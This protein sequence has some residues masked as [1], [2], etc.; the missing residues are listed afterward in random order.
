MQ[1][2]HL[3][4]SIALKADAPTSVEDASPHQ[5]KRLLQTQS[6]FA[7]YHIAINL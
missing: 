4:T 7:F 3:G 2:L 1:F 6:V 5:V